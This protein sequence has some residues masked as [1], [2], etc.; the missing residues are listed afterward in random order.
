[1]TEEIRVFI[2]TDESQLGAAA[3]LKQS[4]IETAS[5]PVRIET[6]ER[7]EIPQPAD[8]RQS[9]RT[10][11][12]FSRWAIPELCNYQGRAIYIDADMMVFTDIKELWEWP[13][14]DATIAIVDGTNTSYCADVAKGNKNE[15]SVMVMDCAKA[16][17]SL[18]SLV[19]GLDGQY[20]YKQMMSDLCFLDESAIVRTIPR[21]WNAMDYWDDSVSLL[22]YTNVPTQPWVTVGNPYGH[23]WVNNVKRLI[24]AGKIQRAFIQEQVDKG[25]FRPSL[26]REIDGE[27]CMNAYDGY[28]R[29]LSALDLKSRFIP[30]RDLMAFTRKRDLAIRSYQLDLLK[31]GD[32]SAYLKAL[33]GYAVA[34]LKYYIKKML[35]RA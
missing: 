34:D 26:M 28:G 6:M 8:V 14:G 17:W 2:G 20:D 1:M 22:H 3:V 11:F 21:R 23:V 10:G 7:V 4:I 33:A 24:A 30:H 32:Q 27:T 35:G 19:K 16:P 31:K 25:Y 13:M 5:M 12:S 9:Q 18:A 29:S 15:T